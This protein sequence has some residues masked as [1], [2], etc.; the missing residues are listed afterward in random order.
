MGAVLWSG[1]WSI[2]FLAA[3]FVYVLGWTASARGRLSVTRA[4]GLSRA[5]DAR[6]RELF[7]N[8]VVGVFRTTLDGRPLTVNP[9]LARLFGYASPEDFLAGVTDVSALYARAGNRATMVETLRSQHSIQAMEIPFVHRDGHEIWGSLSVRFVADGDGRGDELE[10]MIVD[11]TEQRRAQSNLRKAEDRLRTAFKRAP[12]GMALQG[13]DGR[14]LQVNEALCRITGYSEAELL[15]RR[16]QDITHPD[17]LDADEQQAQRVEEGEIPSYSMEKRYVHAQGHDV[18]VVIHASLVHDEAG[19]P[20]HFVTQ[21]EDNTQRKQAQLMLTHMAMHD[22]LTG[23]PNRTLAVDRLEQALARSK[24][25]EG[26]VGVLFL[27]LD[28]FKIVN[29]SLGHGAGDRLLVAAGHRLAKLVRPSDTVARIGGDEF[30]IICED[31]RTQEQAEH[32]A[33]RIVASLSEAFDLGE[34]D[35]ILGTSVGLSLARGSEASAEELIRDADAAMYRAKDSGRSRYVVFD[36]STRRRAVAR[37]ETEQALRHALERDEFVLHYQP[38]IDLDSTSVVGVEALVRWQHPERGLVP[39]MDFIPLAEE[40]GLIIRIGEW[41][42]G[43]A[44]RQH[45]AWRDAAPWGPSLR[46]AVNLSARQLEQPDLA[47]MVETILLENDMDPASLVLEITESV[48]T[49]DGDA[50]VKAL[51]SLKALGVRLSVD[52]FG[53]GYSSL[54]YLKRFPV[55]TLKVDRS[56]VEGLGSDPEDSAIVAGV[57]GLARTLGLSTVAEGVETEQQVRA[58][59]DLGCELAQGF[60]FAKPRPAAELEHP[61]TPVPVSA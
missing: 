58:L 23:L 2:P 1:P 3:P 56:F 8:A 4:E 36:E 24:R 26:L 41:V 57:L 12:I 55:D 51:Q 33:G 27:D 61:A 54:L 32:L 53:T 10:G 50:T 9:A 22:S 42:L 59:R 49:E 60:L 30:M 19:D 6:Y 18:W 45:R 47:E 40:T 20:R 7:D 48:L 21:V 29:D 38:L 28:R 11:I 34:D 44:C 31:L 16:W 13:M 43:E 35:V 5:A 46:L 39:P 25:S 52:D 15:A 14:Y 17:D 37:L